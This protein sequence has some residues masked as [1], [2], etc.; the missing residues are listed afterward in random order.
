MP[1]RNT[2][3]TLC[4]VLLLHLKLTHA[5]WHLVIS[6]FKFN[7][8]NIL[9]SNVLNIKQGFDRQYWF[10]YIFLVVAKKAKAF[11][12]IMDLLSLLLLF[13]FFL[14]NILWLRET[15]LEIV[16]R[17]V[18]SF[19]HY[20]LLKFWKVAV[21]TEANLDNLCYNVRGLKSDQEELLQKFNFWLKSTRLVKMTHFKDS[22]FSSVFVLQ[23]F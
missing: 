6:W 14:L 7:K 1:N 5:K 4:F 8:T 9:D 12:H 21:H 22:L 13:F 15:M 18:F 16:Q 11:C 20:H 10:L 2:Y 17:F 19:K 3:Y 23:W